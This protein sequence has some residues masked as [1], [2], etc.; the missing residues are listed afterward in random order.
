MQLFSADNVNM[1]YTDFVSRIDK[2]LDSRGIKRQVLAKE[3]G[4]SVPNLAKW[5]HGTSKP[6]AE[7][8]YLISQYLGVSMEW[9]LTGK[10]GSDLSDDER[11]LVMM[12][13]ESDDRGKSSVM[14]TAEREYRHC[15]GQVQQNSG[16][17]S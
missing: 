1:E 11:R 16:S 12:Y 2:L 8:V 10:D 14:E 5:K 3:C 9:L 6:I 13:R 17:A 15:L 7:S 4:F